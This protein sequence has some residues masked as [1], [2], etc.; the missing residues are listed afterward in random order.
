MPYQSDAV[1]RLVHR[2]QAGDPLNPWEKFCLLTSKPGEEL[3]RCLE[4]KPPRSTVDR[5]RA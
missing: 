5:Q 4:S 1:Q 3:G 2:I